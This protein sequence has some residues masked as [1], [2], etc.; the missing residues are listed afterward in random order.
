[1][2]YLVRLPLE[3]LVVFFGISLVIYAMTHVL[4]GD[5]VAALAGDRPLSPSD[6]LWTDAPHKDLLDTLVPD[7]R[8]LQ[9]REHAD[10]R[11][12]HGGHGRRD[13]PVGAGG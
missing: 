2:T 9:G 7:R 11:R 4:P 10:H 1:M 8:A 13:G 12:T 3:A 6:A 5:P